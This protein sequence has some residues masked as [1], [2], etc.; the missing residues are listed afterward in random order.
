MP[1]NDNGVANHCD[2]S[3]GNL[4]NKYT[5][6]H[7]ANNPNHNLSRIKSYIDEN[8]KPSDKPEKCVTCG[9]TLQ[10]Y[11]NY[12]VYSCDN[13]NEDLW[14]KYGNDHLLNNLKII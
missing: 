4:C 12:P 14:D 2:N 6:N 13:Y 3:K 7:K 9:D 11:D 8:E 5:K 1:I 10:S